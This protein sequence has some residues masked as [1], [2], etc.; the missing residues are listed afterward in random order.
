MADTAVGLFEDRKTADAVVVALRANGIPPNGIRVLS[1]PVASPVNTPTSTPAVDFNA[2]LA[3]DLRSM[4]AT[5]SDSKTYLDGIRQGKVLV[6]ATGTTEQ[7]ESAIDLMNAYDPVEIE[8]FAGS[9]PA[10]PGL[11]GKEM[12]AHDSI[13]PAS[14]QERA[15]SEG[16]RV[17]SW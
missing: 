13:S 1:Q 12:A 5:E 14:D 4:G 3:R 9:G 6:M 15:K 16:A 7:A 17:F 10:M 2:A 8:E 11:R